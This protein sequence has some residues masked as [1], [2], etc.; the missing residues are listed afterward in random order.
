MG[1]HKDESFKKQ[2][3]IPGKKLKRVNETKTSFVAKIIKTNA[4]QRPTERQ[5]DINFMSIMVTL[6]NHNS[7]NRKS[8]IN[9]LQ[10]LGTT[11]KVI[12]E[13]NVKII[14]ETVLPMLSDEEISVRQL[15][16]TF[17]KFYLKNMAKSIWIHF[18]PQLVTY[19][20][21]GLTNIHIN[22]IKT[23]LFLFYSIV[24]LLLPDLDQ[25]LSNLL[26]IYSNLLI[27]QSS[28][29]EIYQNKD[30]CT[31]YI[32]PTVILLINKLYKSI[33]EPEQIM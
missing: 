18:L 23:T 4:S 9:Q 25:Y 10:S 3:V 6:K 22:I 26:N 17:L 27:K 28:K 1:K 29:T 11:N 16:S 13:E 2:K 33:E 15:V 14:M 31:T 21:H 19:I 20:S 5:D 8:A 24:P 32:L 12:L 7:S 30:I